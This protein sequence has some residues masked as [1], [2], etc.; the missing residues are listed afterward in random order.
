MIMF[1]K[2]QGEIRLFIVLAY[3]ELAAFNCK[4]MAMGCLFFCRSAT[5]SS[6]KIQKLIKA[7]IACLK[8]VS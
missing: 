4:R 1:N 2:L 5:A 6:S 3:M 7:F 8:P